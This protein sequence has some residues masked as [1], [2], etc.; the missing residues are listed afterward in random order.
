MQFEINTPTNIIIGD[1]M[2]QRLPMY[3]KSKYKTVLL[4]SN[5]ELDHHVKRVI[6]VLDP[7]SLNIKT[8]LLENVEPS[9]EYI[10]ATA[11]N[12]RQYKYDLIIGVGGGSAI[13]MAKSLSI[14]L[15]NPKPIWEYANLSNR[16]A[17]K[18]DNMPLPVIAI[19]TT[20]GTGSEVTPYAVLSKLDTQQKGTIQDKAIYPK[21]ALIDPDFLVTMPPELTAYT[22][23]DAFAHAFE[24]FINI[25]KPSPYAEIVACQS[26]NLIFNNL[27]IV[28]DDGNKIQS[29]INM[30]WASSLAGISIG[31]RGTTTPHA[32]AEPLGA[33]TKLPH[34]VAVTLCT[35]PVLK[36]TYNDI[37]DKIKF[38]VNNIQF[39]LEF[40]EQK[41]FIEQ[42]ET[43]YELIG[44]DKK[45][46]DFVD[47]DSGFS[48]ILVENVLQY[49]FRPL[50]QHPIKFNKNVLIEIVNEIIGD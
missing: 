47:F 45:L 12:L 48:S 46:K 15:V 43:L 32:I 16:P 14:A 17:S 28:V 23:I 37:E 35:I 36:R 19:P 33:L 49:K 27:P 11:I 6:N 42:L 24:S 50:E 20:S 30:A 40:I 29:R 13:D 2:I 25:S 10:D 34:A 39:P 8:I 21:L 4:V 41:D 1:D 7:L 22:G 38:L 26:I 18:F 5:K 31:H 44:C 9:T 3:I